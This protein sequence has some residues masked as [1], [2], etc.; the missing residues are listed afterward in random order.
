MYYSVTSSAIR[1][2]YIGEA[3]VT[4]SGSSSFTANTPDVLISKSRT[5]SSITNKR[6]KSTCTH[7]VGL[8]PAAPPAEKEPRTYSLNKSKI[9]KKMT[10]FFNLQATKNFC[11]FYTLTFPSGISDNDAYRI[12]NI[13]Q[14]RC[15]TEYALRSFIWVAERQKNGTIHFHL[16][17]NTRM[18]IRQA[19][20]FIR[21]S[22]TKLCC[23]Y[24]WEASK[25]E[26]YNGLDVDNV[27]HPKRPKSPDASQRRTRDDAARYLGKYIT[28]YVSKNNE[29]FQRLAWHESRDIAALFTA[30]NFDIDEVVPILSYFLSTKEQWKRLECEYLSVY[31]PPNYIDLYHFTDLCR[32]NELV[33]NQ[34]LNTS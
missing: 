3:P 12:F 26:K 28:K 21:E 4:F 29:K 17:T 27:W 31:I 33:Y 19:N 34:S 16:L 20:D 14:T 11:A 24:D 1:E 22:L 25:V 15:R 8:P 2:I 6:E 5:T 13:W 23:A 9:R 32:I 18:P 10:A 7:G 30:Q